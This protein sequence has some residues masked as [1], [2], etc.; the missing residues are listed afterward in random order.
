MLLFTFQYFD[1]FH[2]LFLCS[3]LNELYGL[4]LIYLVIIVI[5]FFHIKNDNPYNYVM[6]WWQVAKCSFSDSLRK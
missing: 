5:A 1:A 2:C 6:D 3:P 4:A